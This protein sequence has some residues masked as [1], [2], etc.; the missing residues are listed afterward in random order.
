MPAPP[1]TMPMSAPPAPMRMPGQGGRMG[2]VLSAAAVVIAILALVLSLAVPGPSGVQGGVGP[3]GPRGDTGLTG[4]TGPAGPSG[5]Q[6]PIGPTGPSG[7]G[8]IVATT[9][10]RV[11][12]GSIQILTTCTNFA[13]AEV[14][15]TVPGPGTIVVYSTFEFSLSHVTGTTD[16]LWVSIS[17]DPAD[18]TLVDHTTSLRFNAAEPTQTYFWTGFVMSPVAVGA[19]MFTFYVNARMVQGASDGGDFLESAATVAVFYPS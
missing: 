17:T 16:L 14:T 18:C 10:L 2:M 12:P 5:P 15:I 13:G 4:P 6:G 3:A 11:T 8:S 9:T 19:G 7:P 1:Q